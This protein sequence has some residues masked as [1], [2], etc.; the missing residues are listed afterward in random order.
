M[1][2][3]KFRSDKEKILAAGTWIKADSLAAKWFEGYRIQME[4]SME[5]FTL[6]FDGFADAIKERFFN[7]DIGREAASKMSTLTY[8]G[9][10]QDYLIQM[11]TLNRDAEMTGPAFQNAVLTGL[12]GELRMRMS[13][14]G[15][16]TTDDRMFTERL[17]SV[18]REYESFKRQEHYLGSRSREATSFSKSDKK[19]GKPFNSSSGGSGGFSKKGINPPK[20]DK[21]KKFPKRFESREEATKG[22]PKWLVDKRLS[23]K[24][25]LRCGMTNHRA[26]FCSREP[27]VS[28]IAERKRSASDD[29]PATKSAKKSKKGK[30]VAAITSRV[31]AIYE[32]SSDEDMSG[33]D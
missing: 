26:L 23:E 20:V 17:A 15:M 6:G 14:P 8:K 27:V 3:R 19:G 18:G 21:N 9:D 25:C 31:E 28:V 2:S 24:A 1:K 33:K 22:V 32:D 4:D 29:P 10:I 11:E 5:D 7:P 13:M 16:A 30:E 12:S